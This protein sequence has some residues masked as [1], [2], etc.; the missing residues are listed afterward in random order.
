MVLVLCAAIA[1]AETVVCTPIRQA[2]IPYTISAAGVYCL[3]TDLITS[4]TSGNVITIA[5]DNVVLD[6]NNHR[7]GGSG[8]GLATTAVG[9]F[10]NSVYNVTIIDGIVRGFEYGIELL[11]SAS[12]GK[13]ANNE[14]YGIRTDANTEYGISVV[15]LGN[16]IHDNVILRTG[17]SSITGTINAYG[18]ASS[19]GGATIRKNDVVNTEEEATGTSY[20]IYLDAS[21]QYSVIDGNRVTD[22]TKGPGTSYGIYVDSANCVVKDNTVFNVTDGIFMTGTTGLYRDNSVINTTTPFTGSDNGPNNASNN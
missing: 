1:Q 18:I 5:S 8:A 16:R 17:G 14:I 7:I 20:A 2:D 10:G 9:I 11:D 13:S 4:M 22:P 6:L 21:S 12:P 19:G 15:G 3:Q